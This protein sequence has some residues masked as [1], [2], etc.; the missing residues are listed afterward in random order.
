MIP[1]AHTNGF[2]LD[3]LVI[4]GTILVAIFVYRTVRGPV[5]DEAEANSNTDAT[6][7]PPREGGT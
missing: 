5:D 7:P 4:F 2:G 3:E 6:K 1:V